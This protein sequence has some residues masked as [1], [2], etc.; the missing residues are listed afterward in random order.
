MRLTPSGAAIRAADGGGQAMDF[1]ADVSERP[2]RAGRAYGR[3]AGAPDDDL[4]RCGPGTLGGELLRRY[5]Q[6]LCRSDEADRYP[7]LVRILG[8]D[9]ILFRDGS[10]RPGL[11]YPRCM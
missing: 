6:P 5:W 2:D 1:G 3:K 9:L 8:E 4:V 7:K 11:L 10:G